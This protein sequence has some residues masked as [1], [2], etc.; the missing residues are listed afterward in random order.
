MIITT[1]IRVA[2]VAMATLALAVPTQPDAVQIDDGILL[3]RLVCPDARYK[4]CGTMCCTPLERCSYLE[5]IGYACFDKKKSSSADPPEKALST[6][7]STY[8][9]PDLNTMLITAHDDSATLTATTTETEPDLSTMPISAHGSSSI[10][11][12]PTSGN[13]TPGATTIPTGSGTAA[14]ATTTTRNSAGR[15]DFRGYGMT[16]LASAM[17]GYIYLL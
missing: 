1:S 12:A 3:P 4:P 5:L 10:T 2:I 6:Y 8:T 14:V 7:T 13:P 15:V 9:E 16:L 11:T 17:F